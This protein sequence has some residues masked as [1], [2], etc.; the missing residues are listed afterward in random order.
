L[1]GIA[2]RDIYTGD[3]IELWICDKTGIRK[4]HFPLRR[5]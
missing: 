4:K 5:D 3:G 1:N 2:E